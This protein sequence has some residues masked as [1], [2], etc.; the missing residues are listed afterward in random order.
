MER[1]NSN[2]AWYSEDDE[3][4]RSL[5]HDAPVPGSHAQGVAITDE[6]LMMAGRNYGFG[7]GYDSG[8]RASR[9]IPGQPG[10]PDSYRIA[11]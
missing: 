3:T 11:E 10:S 7:A 2:D 1:G 8:D 6:F 4:W 9:K 5:P